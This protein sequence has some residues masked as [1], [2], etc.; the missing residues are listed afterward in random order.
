[1]FSITQIE[2]YLHDL[3]KNAPALPRNIRDNLAKATPWLALI[4]GVLQI[5]GAFALAGILSQANRIEQAYD[6]AF[7]TTSNVPV[8]SSAEE[9]LIYIGISLLFIQAVLLLLS[10]PRLMRFEYK[11]WGHLFL[12]FLINLLY[13]VTA[14][15]IS[16]RSV[17]SFLWNILVCGIS[18]Y[19]LFQI[20]GHF[21]QRDIHNTPHSRSKVKK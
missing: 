7:G 15:F 4:Y 17:S 2:K 13:A 10:V 21:E 20:R 1:M 8:L 12:V 16:D 5:L 19:L 11:G 9:L 6:R 14:L 3:Y 18:F